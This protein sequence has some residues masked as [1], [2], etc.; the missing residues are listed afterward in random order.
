MLVL[1]PLQISEAMSSQAID[2][3]FNTPVPDLIH[4]PPIM[5]RLEP[6]LDE[7]AVNDKVR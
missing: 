5:S 6:I 2:E 3:V 7:I 4:C 1:I